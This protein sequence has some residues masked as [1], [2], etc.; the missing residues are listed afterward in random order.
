MGNHRQSVFE[1][2]GEG[3]RRL[4]SSGAYYAWFKHAGKQYHISVRISCPDIAEKMGLSKGQVSKLEKKAYL[5]G[6]LTKEG[7]EYKLIGQYHAPAVSTNFQ[8]CR[9]ARLAA[10]G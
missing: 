1:R 6:W 5:D 10:S 7:R 8:V 4:V 9:R 2:S 3:L